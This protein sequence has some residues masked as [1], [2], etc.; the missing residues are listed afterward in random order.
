MIE[1][2]GR[3]RHN[4]DRMLDSPLAGADQQAARVE[5]AVPTGNRPLARQL[6]PN[7]RLTNVIDRSDTQMLTPSNVR[8]AKVGL[9]LL[10]RAGRT[11]YLTVDKT[12]DAGRARPHQG[13]K[14]GSAHPRPPQ[15]PL[16]RSARGSDRVL[17]MI[18]YETDIKEP[19][20]MI[21]NNS[22]NL[23]DDIAKWCHEI[24]PEQ[25]NHGYTIE[26]L[27]DGQH[28]SVSSEHRDAA[29]CCGCVQRTDEGK[30]SRRGQVK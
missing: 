25:H 12:H 5:G 8:E 26:A 18:E 7:P 22:S 29:L 11:R 27:V 4:L 19:L 14:S 15:L 28:V 23:A 3:D 6:P 17:A 20:N 2:L 24:I 10:G 1:I 30:S 9:A 16:R 13:G 21:Q